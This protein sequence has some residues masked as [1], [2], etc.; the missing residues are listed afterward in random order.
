MFWIKIKIQW[1]AQDVVI[2][3]DQLGLIQLFILKLCGVQLGPKLRYSS[4]LLVLLSY[5]SSKFSDI[6]LF[7]FPF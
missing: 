2:Q 5:Y 7:Q 1:L 3:F 4:L 6:F